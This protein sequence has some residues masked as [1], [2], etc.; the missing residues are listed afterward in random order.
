M[1]KG[2]CT[3]KWIDLVIRKHSAHWHRAWQVSKTGK[4]YVS[5]DNAAWHNE[6]EFYAA[7]KKMHLGGKV[8]RIPL[9]PGSPDVHKVVEHVIGLL[10][11]LLNKALR[12][13]ATLCTMKQY[14]KKAEQIFNHIIKTSGIQKDIASLPSTYEA[15]LA[16]GGGWAPP[17]KR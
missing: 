12:E 13:D 17:K 3:E 5:F 4:A 10:K 1:C 14:K 15:V 16:A 2:L 8:E 11:R 9:P 6:E 7:V